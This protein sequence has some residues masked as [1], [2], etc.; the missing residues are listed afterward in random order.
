VTYT[1]SNVRV[2]ELAKELGIPNR[3]LITALS[4]LGIEVK[5][6]ASSLDEQSVDLVKQKI[7]KEKAAREKV[8]SQKKTVEPVTTGHRVEKT[9]EVEPPKETPVVNEEAELIVPKGRIELPTGITVR[10]LAELLDVPT[11]TIQKTLVK[12]GA[13]VAVNQVIPPGLAEK[14]VE[15]LGYIVV[16]P[17]PPPP[18]KVEEEPVPVTPPPPKP[19]ETLKAPPP[20]PS[21]PPAPEVEVTVPEVRAEVKPIVPRPKPRPEHKPSLEP[22]PPVV[23]ILG[24]VDHGKTTLLDAIRQTNVTDKEFGGITQHIGAYQ[25]DVKGKKITFIDTPGHEAFT[26]MRAR[27][28]QVTDIAVLVVAAD[29][30][31][32]PQTIEAINHARAA[33]VQIIVAINKIDKPDANVE[34]TKQQL[35]EQ[36]LVVEEWGGDTVCVEVSAKEKKGLDELLEMILLVAELAE[37]KADPRGEVEATVI[38]AKLDKGKGPVATVL[39]KSGTLEVGDA[40]VVGQAYGKIKAMMDD[41]GN[42]ISKAGPS[43]PVEIIGLSSVPQAGDRVET[44]IDEREARQVAEAR[45]EQQRSVEQAQQVRVTLADLYKQLREG[46]VKEL[47]IILKGDVQGS[48]EA[49]RESLDKLSTQEV[50]VNIIHSGV[51]NV[52]ESDILLASASNAVVV[53]FN[54]KVDA[55]AKRMADSEGVEVRTYRVIYE[56]LE[57]IKGAMAGML[58]P[59]I[60]ETILGHA[61]VRQVF[62]LPRGVVAGCYVTDGK[63]QR[64]S[65]ARVQRG[66]QTIYTGKISSLRHIKEDMREIAAGYECGIMMEGF[67]DFEVGDVIESYVVQ[68]VARALTPSR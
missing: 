20:P 52:N 58:A 12:Q 48:V 11:A 67:Q 25:V 63:V 8:E 49:I 50:R 66:G 57:D 40:I 30:G 1:V 24:H 32:M 14:V 7:R 26:A 61:E 45:A 34:R 21:A 4:E 41:R 16:A 47:N 31:V 37:L 51:G 35:A 62:R 56:L 33:G 23:T 9:P 59:V 19:S 39:V 36:G 54:V 13:L 60:E 38:E 42:R 44:A 10:E 29:D 2:H 55:Q 46:M 6:H 17:P 53:G 15:S 3:D 27:G 18:P 5:S 65:D 28:A 43:T 64:G 22:R 68:E